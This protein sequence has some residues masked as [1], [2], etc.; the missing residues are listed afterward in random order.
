MA[1]SKNIQ[2]ALIAVGAALLTGAVVVFGLPP[3]DAAVTS[4]P[5]AGR[6]AVA[7][8]TAAPPPGSVAATAPATASGTGADAARD[9]SAAPADG[10]APPAF[11]VVRVSPEGDSVI[12]GRATPGKTLELLVDGRVHDKVDVPESGTF[13]LTPPALP[14]GDHELTLREVGE[15]GADTVSQQS[16]TVVLSPDR[17]SPPVVALTEP[18]KPTALLSSGGVVARELN[19]TPEADVIAQA[20]PGDDSTAA[21]AET[22]APATA[23]APPDNVVIA[24]VEAEAGRL[25]V[26]GQAPP[27]SSVRLYLNDTFLAQGTASDGAGVSF[28]IDSGIP[29]GDYH[30]R[31]DQVTPDDGKVLSRAEV[32]FSMPEA[33][34]E[35]P[36]AT[37]GAPGPREADDGSHV[38]VVPEV[39]AVRVERGDTLWRISR[40]VYGRGVRYTVIYDANQE[41]IRNPDRIYPGQLFVL[42]GE[43]GGISR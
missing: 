9:P 1:T 6:P 27:G 33:P 7:P 38:V 42:P 2:L 5:P 12:A 17:T 36:S 37:A 34:L 10:A 16:V 43:P 22:P 11:D 25:Y 39:R 32:P 30:V 29:P 28:R 41:Q 15:D 24:T 19:G 21:P 8:G 20:A 26:S 14:P 13:A 3:R 31:L 35:E 18:D 40:R 4:A 23:A